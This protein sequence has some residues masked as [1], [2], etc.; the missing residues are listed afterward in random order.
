[1][2]YLKLCMCC[3][4][5]LVI[6]ECIKVLMKIMFKFF[7]GLEILMFIFVNRPSFCS[8]LC[9]LFTAAH[10]AIL[11]ETSTDQVSCLGQQFTFK[12]QT[13]CW[14]LFRSC[15]RVCHSIYWYAYCS[16]IVLLAIRCYLTAII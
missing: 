13:V 6:H 9:Q 2:F 12:L 7:V 14:A 5:V 4:S 3:V 15:C 8:L 1:M 11:A 16:I 10:R